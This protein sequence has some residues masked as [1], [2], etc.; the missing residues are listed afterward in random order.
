MW[1]LMIGVV[2][3]AAATL[4]TAT[5]T[6]AAPINA[7]RTQV[8]DGLVGGQNSLV[9]QVRFTPPG[10]S[11][12][13]KV[14]WHNALTSGCFQ[15]LDLSGPRHARRDS[16]LPRPS[17]IASTVRYTALAPDRFKGFWRD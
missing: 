16:G 14:G 4:I 10:F 8:S 7:A 5:A 3:V 2:A 15:R 1:R 6:E 17:S 12:G 13:R 9:T 11:H